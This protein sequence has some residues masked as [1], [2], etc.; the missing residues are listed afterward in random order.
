MPVI[1]LEAHEDGEDYEIGALD[2]R[3]GKVNIWFNRDYPINNNRLRLTV[4]AIL[5][6]MMNC[7]KQ[8]DGLRKTAG[9]G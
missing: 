1:L 8:H 4:T 9:D 6:G 2:V 3:D 7:M 5:S